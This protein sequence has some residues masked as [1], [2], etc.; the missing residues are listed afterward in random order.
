MFGHVFANGATPALTVFGMQFGWMLGSTVLV[1]EI[2][3]RPGIGRYAVKAVT[4]SD[5]HGVVAVVLIV[6]LFFLIANLV[7][8]LLLYLLNPHKHQES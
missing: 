5:I 8:D 4:Q 2:F 1:E 3:G 6:G 7:V